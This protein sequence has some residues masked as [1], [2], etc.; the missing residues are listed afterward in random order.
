MKRY[1]YRNDYKNWTKD[2]IKKH[3]PILENKLLENVGIC[4]SNTDNYSKRI[5]YLKTKL[6]KMPK[7]STS[8]NV[9]TTRYRSANNLR[10]LKSHGLISG[11]EY[12]VRMKKLGL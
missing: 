3:L 12:Q 7:T 6:T 2:R 1:D 9:G 5:S 4:E 8:A 10:Y 11:Y